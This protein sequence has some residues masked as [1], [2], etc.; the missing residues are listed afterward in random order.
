M[1][2]G[3]VCLIKGAS[4]QI[5]NKGKD[6]SMRKLTLRHT[7]LRHFTQEVFILMHNFG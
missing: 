7:P 1:K 4:K 3:G 5:Q 6:T 2:K